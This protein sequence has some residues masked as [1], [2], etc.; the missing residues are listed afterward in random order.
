MCGSEVRSDVTD[1]CF[2]DERRLVASFSNGCVALFKYQDLQK[3]W[4]EL[5][6]AHSLSVHVFLFL[7]EYACTC[8]C[9]VVIYHVLFLSG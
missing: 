9:S 4:S 7:K 3:V 5:S 6:V 2:L 1:L 8:T